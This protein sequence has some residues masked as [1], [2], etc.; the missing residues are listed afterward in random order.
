MAL[1]GM[2]GPA[3]EWPGAV[4]GKFADPLHGRE[5]CRR[6]VATMVKEGAPHGLARNGFARY[7]T[8]TSGLLPDEGKMQVLVKP[9]GEVLAWRPSRR[10]LSEPGS[11]HYE[12]PEGRRLVEE[13]PRQLRGT[14][15]RRHLRPA[16]SK[17]AQEC[18]DRPTGVRI[19]HRENGLRALDQPAREVDVSAEMARKARALDLCTQRNGVGCRSLGDKAYRQPEYETGF[20][21]A[22]SLI[23]GSSFMRGNFKKTEPRNSTSV[24]LVLDT[25]KKHVQS[26]EE[27]FHE[28]QVQEAQSEVQYLTGWEVSTLKDC[29]EARYQDV[30]SDDDTGAH[31]AQP[32]S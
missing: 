11:H 9:G 20:H 26:Y 5:L 13:Q 18:R 25:D 1:P 15:E 27:K 10:S 16:E 19:V 31:L 23:V 12:K 6:Q 30:D 32:R 14:A 4:S 17:E 28:R 21:A 24:V 29:D 3:P 7:F 8:D 2:E 22:G